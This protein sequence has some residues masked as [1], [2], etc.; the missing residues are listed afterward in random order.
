MKEQATK[1]LMPVNSGRGSQKTL[2]LPTA[3][4]EEL[5]YPWFQSK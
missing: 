4:V 3:A 2:V 1:V 5:L